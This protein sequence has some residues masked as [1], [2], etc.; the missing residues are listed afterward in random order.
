[1]SPKARGRRVYP[2]TLADL[3]RPLTLETLEREKIE[4]AE[5]AK[6]AKER[7]GHVK[8]GRQRG[9]DRRTARDARLP[10]VRAMSARGKTI[11]Q[12]ATG[13]GRQPQNDPQGFGPEKT[14][15]VR[16]RA[17][18]IARVTALVIHLRAYRR[19]YARM[20]SSRIRRTAR[21]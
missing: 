16:K 21:A 9:E 13:P 5:H 1:V 6:R 7:A 20:L 11:P 14:P 3:G 19:R 12:I 18:A 10:R 8:G 2:L 15:P 4:Q 17:R